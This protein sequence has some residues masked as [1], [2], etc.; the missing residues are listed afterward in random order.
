MTLPAFDLVQPASLDEAL[1]A[2][3]AGAESKPISGGTSLLVNL[4]DERETAEQ[5]VDLTRV[6]ELR[7]IEDRGHELKIGAG[8]LIADLM[9][10]PLVEPN[11]PILVEAAKTFASPL[12]RNR[13]TVG[14]NLVDASPAA[15]TAPPLLALGAVVD[16]TSAQG[17]RTLPLEEFFV[18][19]RKTAIRPDEIMTAVRIPAAR[20]GTLTAYH[21]LG[22]R[23]ADAISVISVAVCVTVAD[24][25]CHEARIALGAVAPTPFVAKEASEALSGSA[26]TSETIASAAAL[27]AKACRPIDDV[28]ASAEYRRRTVETLVRRVLTEIAEGGTQ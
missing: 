15:D 10:C 17:T 2:L 12:V 27:A 3:G 16:L 25:I 21:K 7:G 22:L 6:A 18:G 1:E 19:V 26:L 20:E 13:A 8:N 23:K 14:G 5:L 4:R 28:R 11:V 24:G 9:A